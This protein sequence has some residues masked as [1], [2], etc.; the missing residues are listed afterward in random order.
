MK[1]DRWRGVGPRQLAAHLWAR[2]DLVPQEAS[3][4]RMGLLIPGS[5]GDAAS[6]RRRV[7]GNLYGID[8]TSARWRGDALT[9][10]RRRRSLSLFV[11]HK[12]GYYRI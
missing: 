11:L 4:K 8:A 7:V 1:S 2:L 10:G 9:A 5:A 3:S 12:R 6:A